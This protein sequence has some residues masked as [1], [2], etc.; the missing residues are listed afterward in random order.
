[1]EQLEEKRRIYCRQY[2]N[3]IKR[4]RKAKNISQQELAKR[5][6][7]SK[8][9]ISKYENGTLDMP[10]SLL[11]V[12][13]EVCGFQFASYMED[14]DMLT[15]SEKNELYCYLGMMEVFTYYQEAEMTKDMIQS[16]IMLSRKINEVLKKKPGLGETIRNLSV[17]NDSIK[18]DEK[19]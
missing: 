6:K 7:L 19:Q 2:G 4:K 18:K 5:L 17:I 10:S 3:V 16:R 12:I 8:S 15:L 13:S 11:P 14:H 1:M 9:T